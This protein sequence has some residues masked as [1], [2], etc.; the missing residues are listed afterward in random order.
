MST[1]IPVWSKR[2]TSSSICSRSKGR[3]G[4][5]RMCGRILFKGNDLLPTIRTSV[6]VCG[7]PAP[8]AGR[9]RDDRFPGRRRNDLRNRR[10]HGGLGR[11]RA[12]R[13]QSGRFRP[14]LPQG[15][16]GPAADGR[17]Q[18][19]ALDPVG[20]GAARVGSQVGHPWPFPSW[21]LEQEKWD[22]TSLKKPAPKYAS[23]REQYADWRVGV[24][25]GV[26]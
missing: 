14:H 9:P 23:P 5:V 26:D 8:C 21:S 22:S 1:N 12:R 18:E 24:L 7:G 3:P 20:G 10:R 13:H 15:Q 25:P 16:G 17:R 6:T 19:Q 2:R 11:A 4:R